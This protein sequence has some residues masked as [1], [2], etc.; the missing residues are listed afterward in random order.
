MKELRTEVII[1]APVD[2]VWKILTETGA[3][4]E[5]NPFIREI[6]GKLEEGKRFKVKLQPPG[7][8]PMVFKPVCLSL[9]RDR[10]LI[11]LGHLLIRGLFDGKHIFELNAIGPTKTKL[12]QREEFSGLLVPFF[13]KQLDRNTRTGFEQMNQKMKERAEK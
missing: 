9:K 4:P 11:W 3:Y 6:E 13:W 12:V 10:E 1:D 7:S 2:I 8:S 5:W